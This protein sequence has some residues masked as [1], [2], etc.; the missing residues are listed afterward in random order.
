MTT[1]V[2]PDRQARVKTA[3]N[4]F[5]VMAWITGVFLLALV[6]RM[7]CQ[8]ILKLDI[9]EWATWIAITHGWV[10]IGYVIS[11]MNLGMKAL[12]PFSRILGT[13]LAG[14]VPFFSFF[15]EASRR[16]QVKEEFQLS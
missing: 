3:L 10:Y 12:W 4:I 8:Y 13:A 5:S 16:K 6:V 9:P 11:V 2:H 14:V 7:V 1:T 15:M